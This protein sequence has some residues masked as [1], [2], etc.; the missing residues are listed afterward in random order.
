[1]ELFVDVI[2]QI[3]FVADLEIDSF[4]ISSKVEDVLVLGLGVL[5]M[6]GFLLAYTRAVRSD[7]VFVN[8][9]RNW[10]ELGICYIYDLLA[11]DKVYSKRIIYQRVL[12]RNCA[13][14]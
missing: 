5:E 9:I 14:Y 11:N 8:I 4:A 10:K 2:Y 6:A 3:L 1:M 7:E 12:N 13:K